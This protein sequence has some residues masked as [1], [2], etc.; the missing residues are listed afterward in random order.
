MPSVAKDLLALMKGMK[1][2]EIVRI[3]I[4]TIESLHKAAMRHTVRELTDYYEC[5]I[6]SVEKSEIEFEVSA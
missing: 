5:N 1:P 6:I 2:G 4:Q 3:E